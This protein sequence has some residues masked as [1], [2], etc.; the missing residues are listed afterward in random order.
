[1]RKFETLWEL[2]KY[3]TD[4]WS[5]KMLLGRWCLKTYSKQG[6]HKPSIKKNE[7]SA[8]HSKMQ[9]SKTKYACMA[10]HEKKNWFQIKILPQLVMGWKGD[11][12]LNSLKCCSKLV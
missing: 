3:D 10:N 6:C 12:P 5:G 2:P 1:M 7:L 11:S 8:K 9:H 4:T